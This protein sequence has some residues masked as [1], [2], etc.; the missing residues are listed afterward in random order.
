MNLTDLNFHHLLCFWYIVRE[1]SLA[2]AAKRLRL[3][4]PTLSAHLRE[5][6]GRLHGPLF[7]RAGRRMVLTDLGRVV[8]EHADK[9][10]AQAHAFTLAL[11]GVNQKLPTLRLG[12]GENFPHLVAMDLFG[13]V[14][15]EYSDMRLS[16]TSATSEI[17]LSGVINGDLDMALLDSG[18]YRD[19]SRRLRW[20]VFADSP[21]ALFAPQPLAKRLKRNFPQSLSNQPFLMPGTRNPLRAKVQTWLDQ[22][23]SPPTIVGEF[24][25]S[26]L[27]KA[28]AIQNPAC[29]IMPQVEHEHL[30]KLYGVEL[31][32]TI[33]SVR[34]NYYIVALRSQTPHSFAAKLLSRLSK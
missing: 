1:G 31:C 10:F 22:L 4:Q 27:M 28:F 14:V 7:H 34:Q 26:A 12:V 29:F 8:A 33:E 17:L 13:L 2:A 23:P 3:S 15:R 11:S 6:E 32:Q 24:D 5:L 30:R 25:N 21:L 20:I 9:I 18:E 16:V 19:F